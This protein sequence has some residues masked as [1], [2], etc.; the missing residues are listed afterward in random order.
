MFYGGSL[1]CGIQ[2]PEGDAGDKC[3][4]P[5]G[6][7]FCSESHQRSKQ[8]QAKTKPCPKRI[9]LSENGSGLVHD[10]FFHLP[11]RLTG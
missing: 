6:M 11:L 8:D 7:K 9:A 1:N 3:T 10:S 5:D 2:K 4:Q